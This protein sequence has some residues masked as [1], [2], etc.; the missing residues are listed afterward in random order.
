VIALGVPDGPILALCGATASASVCFFIGR[1]AGRK[2][3]RAVLG[4]RGD[5]VSEKLHNISIAG[6][7]FLR[8]LPVA[9]FTVVNFTIGISA[10]P[11]S[12]FLIGTILGLAPGVAAMSFMRGPLIEVWRHPDPAGIATFAAI[13][14][15]WFLFLFCLHVVARR[16][17]EHRYNP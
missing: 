7:A 4:K 10:V 5:A 8:M 2:A 1:L 9:P 13:L 12:T 17:H 11:F 15:G 16:W 6:I 3:M 14:C